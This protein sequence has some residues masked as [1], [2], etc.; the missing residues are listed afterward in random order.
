[1]DNNNIAKRMKKYEAVSKSVL[2]NRMPVILLFDGKA[3]HTSPEDSKDH[4]MM[5]LLRLCR[6]RQS[7]F[8]KMFRDVS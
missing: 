7:I 6:K 5:F 2:M 4:L 1:M 3:F 8:V